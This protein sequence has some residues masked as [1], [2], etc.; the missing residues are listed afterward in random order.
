MIRIDNIKIDKSLLYDEIEYLIDVIDNNSDVKIVN[1]K[2]SKIPVYRV[3]DFLKYH[4]TDFLKNVYKK[5]LLRDIDNSELNNRL[6]LLR[7]G[8]VS[9]GEL[10]ARIRFSKEGRDKNIKIIGIEKRLIMAIS[11]RIPIINF[12]VKLFMLPRLFSR[13]NRFEY[14]YFIDKKDFYIKI[15]SIQKSL[16]LM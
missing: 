15:D 9:K 11:N 8:K 6:N 1:L 2:K 12:F 7:S 14:Q 5:V 4:D 3:E 16:I 10:L 13:L